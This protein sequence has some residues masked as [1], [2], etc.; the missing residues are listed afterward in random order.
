MHEVLG[1]S[2]SETTKPQ[3]PGTRNVPG[4]CGFSRD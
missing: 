4:A 3:A 1:S 2:P